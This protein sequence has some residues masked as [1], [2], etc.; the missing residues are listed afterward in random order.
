MLTPATI[1][2][3]LPDLSLPV[4][5]LPLRTKVTKK[6]GEGVYGEVFLCESR[7]SRSVIKIMP[8][9]GDFEVNYAAQKSYG[10]VLSELL[11]SK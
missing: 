5:P 4:S 8:I 2:P 3:D 6:I 1:R 11:I 9:E 7:I 10:E